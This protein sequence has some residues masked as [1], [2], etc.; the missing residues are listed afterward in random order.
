MNCLGIVSRDSGQTRVPVPPH[1]MT[2]CIFFVI[3]AS[4]RASAGLADSSRGGCNSSFATKLT[5]HFRDGQGTHEATMSLRNGRRLAGGPIDVDVGVASLRAGHRRALLERR[6]GVADRGAPEALHFHA[7]FDSVGVRQ[8]REKSAIALGH[9]TD[10]WT[11][12]GIQQAGLDED[13]IYRR[14]EKLVVGDVVQ[15]AVDV[16]VA[17]TRRHP[18]ETRKSD[19]AERRFALARA[20][21]GS[22]LAQASLP[23]N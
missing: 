5:T 7:D 4:S 1:M 17:P 10:D 20:A 19:A 15:V 22:V 11:G 3:G 9:K 6:Q 2:G 12:A 23:E 18:D 14:V 13:L 21:A 8:T 16:V